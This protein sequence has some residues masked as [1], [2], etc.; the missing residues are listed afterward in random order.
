MKKIFVLK[1]K[2]GSG[3]T[4]KI[5]TIADWII[6]T[7]NVQNTIGLDVTNFQKDTFGILTIGKLKIGINSAGDNEGEVKKLDLLTEKH[8]NELDVDIIIC[9]CRTK[10]KGR[11]YIVDNYNYSNGWL[12]KIINIDK[13]TSSDILSQN[14]RDLRKI[15]ELKT[16][17]IGLEK[18]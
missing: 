18:I 3:K 11:K 9:A 16:W 4:T 8:E 5:N 1:G 14:A 10:G 7:Y 12:Q 6:K 13:F 2:D 15:E 17:L